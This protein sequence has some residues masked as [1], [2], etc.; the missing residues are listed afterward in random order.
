MIQINSSH[1]VGLYYLTL[2]LEHVILDEA[3]EMLNM[4]FA[5]SIEAILEKVYVLLLS[6]SLSFII[7]I[8]I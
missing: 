2:K 6:F 1:M 8:D 5:D 4:G 3:D 7:Y